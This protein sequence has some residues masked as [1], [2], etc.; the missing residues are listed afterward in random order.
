M[1]RLSKTHEASWWNGSDKWQPSPLDHVFASNHLKF[2]TFDGAEIEV[3][4]WPDE[5]TR[6]SQRRWIERYS[7]HA[8]LYGEVLS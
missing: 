1:R 3:D 5:T 4:G 2:R 7:D 6:A 8:L